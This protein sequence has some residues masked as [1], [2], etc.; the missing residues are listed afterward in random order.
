MVAA[1]A[2]T[3]TNSK[4]VVAEVQE[5]EA[6]VAVAVEAMAEVVVAAAIIVSSLRTTQCALMWA[7]D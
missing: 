5:A 4:V 6:V 3:V 2:A 7:V 1:R